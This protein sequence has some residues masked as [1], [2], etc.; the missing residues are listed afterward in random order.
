MGDGQHHGS[1]IA[2]DAKESVMLK[3]GHYQC[4]V[5]Q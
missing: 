5:E 1:M 3:A 2:N 4:M